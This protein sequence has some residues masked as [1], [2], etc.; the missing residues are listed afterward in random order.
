MPSM[1]N[2]LAERSP[3]DAQEKMPDTKKSNSENRLFLAEKHD[4][5]FHTDY[6]TL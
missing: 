3:D 4:K 6:E 2:G 5:D 1:L